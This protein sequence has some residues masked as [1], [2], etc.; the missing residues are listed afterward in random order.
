M[1]LIHTATLNRVD[2]FAYLVALLHHTEDLAK[3]PAAWMPWAYQERLAGKK[4][5]A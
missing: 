3:D 2:P 4:A 5:T 1:S